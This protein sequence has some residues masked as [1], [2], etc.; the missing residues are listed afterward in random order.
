MSGRL[1]Y[2]EITV[3]RIL[4]KKLSDFGERFRTLLGCL[5]MLQGGA[6][7]MCRRVGLEVDHKAP[8][9]KGWYMFRSRVLFVSLFMACLASPLF[10][11]QK[12]FLDSIIEFGNHRFARQF[13]VGME[14]D[15][16]SITRDRRQ[17]PQSLQTTLFRRP[18]S[19][20]TSHHDGPHGKRT[21]QNRRS[22]PGSILQTDDGGT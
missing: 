17:S 5:C 16:L 20:A 4:L 8:L 14:L 11:G 10:A 12:V 19:E 21:R 22:R 3:N 6:L 15:R 1:R 18:R 7:R 2:V 13:D 9:R